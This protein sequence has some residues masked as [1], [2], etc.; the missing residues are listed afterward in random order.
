MLLGLDGDRFLGG[1]SDLYTNFGPNAPIVL[2]MFLELLSSLETVRSVI[3]LSVTNTVFNCCILCSKL[4]LVLL[5]ILN[6]LGY[7]RLAS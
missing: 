3:S 1:E 7:S 6:L 4:A 5:S 2:D